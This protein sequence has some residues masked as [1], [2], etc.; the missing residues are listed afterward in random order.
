MEPCRAA[1]PEN[2]FLPVSLRAAPASSSSQ[3]GDSAAEITAYLNAG[4]DGF[5]TDDPAVGRT[6]VA[7]YTRNR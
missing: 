1:L 6:A 4:I 3:R 2:P 5:F 7:A